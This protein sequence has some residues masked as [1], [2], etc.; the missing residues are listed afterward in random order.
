MCSYILDMLQ[1]KTYYCKT[2]VET[3]A[4]LMSLSDYK[5]FQLPETF[6]GPTSCKI[7]LS[8]ILS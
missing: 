4:L 6:P 7:H 5:S 3:V 1:D 2:L 8:Y